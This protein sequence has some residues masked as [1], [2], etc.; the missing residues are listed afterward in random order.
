MSIIIFNFLL[1]ILVIVGTIVLIK[2]AFGESIEA[3]AEAIAVNSVA[4]KINKSLEEGFYDEELSEPL[5]NVQR[6][7][8]GNIQYVEPNSRVINKLLLEFSQNA[9]ETYSLSDRKEH[10]VNLG[11][12]TGS[13]ILSQLPIYIKIKSSAPEPDEISIRNRIR[14]RRNKSDQILYI[15][16]RHQP[17][18]YFG[19][20]YRQDRGNKQKSPSGR[21]YNSRRST[22]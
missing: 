19:A 5:L 3:A 2:D 8:E 10:K 15:L 12:I 21:G 11:V 16:H 20:F 4:V 6:D 7:E 17:S 22:G 14:D 18:T 13:R 9:E 1:I